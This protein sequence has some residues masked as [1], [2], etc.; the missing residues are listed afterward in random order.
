MKRHRKKL[1]RAIENLSDESPISHRRVKQYR[2]EF[3]RKWTDDARQN[4]SQTV[5]HMAH[6]NS[7]KIK[8]HRHS[9]KEEEEEELGNDESKEQSLESISLTSVSP[10]KHSSNNSAFVHLPSKSSHDNLECKIS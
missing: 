8:R 6:V 4:Y 2:N 3:I 7:K 10:M 9:S 5:N 1:G